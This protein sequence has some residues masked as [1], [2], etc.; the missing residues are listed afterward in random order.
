VIARPSRSFHTG[1]VTAALLVAAFASTG[2][3]TRSSE[4][5]AQV[6]PPLEPTAY[7]VTAP[8]VRLGVH[9][10]ARLTP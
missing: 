4:G 5:W 2:C 7:P 3:S 10:P 1:I 9:G 6:V 8:D